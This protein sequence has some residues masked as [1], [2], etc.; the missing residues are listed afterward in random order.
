VAAVI[1]RDRAGGRGQVV[2]VCAYECVLRYMEFLPI[3]FQQLGFRNERTGNSSSYQVPVATWLTADDK[4]VTFTGNTNE[5]VHR[6]YRAMGRHDLVTDGRF[7]TNEGRVANRQLVEATLADWARSHPRAE[8]EALCAEQ[9]VP[10]G[11]VFGMDDI[12]A[13][14]NYLERGTIIEVDDPD[15]GRCRLPGVV[16]RLSRTPGA[17]RHLGTV[18]AVLLARRRPARRH[19]VDR[20]PASGCWTSARS[21]PGPSP[22]PSWPTSGPTSSRWRSPGGTTTAVRPPSTRACPCGGSRAAA[23][24]ARSPWT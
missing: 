8:L 2:D 5:V 4:W 6:L 15:L 19:G 24:S 18:E 22:P 7:A 3:Y 14:Q 23:T 1:E 10:V 11:I 13:D 12:Y 9:G 17:V 21:W 20:W 16:P